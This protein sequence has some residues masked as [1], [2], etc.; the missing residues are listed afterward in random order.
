MEKQREEGKGQIERMTKTKREK[1]KQM[2]NGEREMNK[3]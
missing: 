1:E 2:R 3:L